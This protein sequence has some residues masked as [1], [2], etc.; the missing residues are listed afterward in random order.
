M[1]YRTLGRTGLEVS[2]VGFGCGAIG[3]M[4]VRGTHEAQVATVQRALDHGITYFDT[5]ASYGDGLSE[6]HVGEVFAE[7]KPQVHLGTK[8]TL[9]PDDLGDIIGGVRRSLEAS[10]GR[11]QMGRVDLLQL[12][13]PVVAQRDGRGLAVQDV[14]GPG[15][16]ADA[17]ETLKGEGLIGHFGLTGLGETDPLLDVIDSGRFDT[18]QTYFNMLNPSA[19]EVVPDNFA[20]Q[21]YGRLM[22]RAAAQGMG[23]IVIRVMAGGALAGPDSRAGVAAPVVGGALSG[24]HDYDSDVRRVEALAKRLKPATSMP[25]TAV[26]FALDRDAVSAVLVGFSTVEQIDEAVQA[27]ADEPLS[28]PFSEELAALWAEG[29]A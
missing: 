8:F 12:H 1:R 22:A 3:G 21:D 6:T 5:A 11:L 15:G 7:V 18:V 17:L 27:S 29:I 14:L 24:G 4:M 25:R 19:W 13:N 26:R 20:T 9:G 28:G 16:V 2:E 23:V 10:L